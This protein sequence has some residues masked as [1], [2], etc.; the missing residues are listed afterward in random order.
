MKLGVEDINWEGRTLPQPSPWQ[1]SHCPRS[2]TWQS[3]AA[4]S[5][6]YT[7]HSWNGL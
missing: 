7:W 2:I 3:L 5:S 1:F 4:T 6:S